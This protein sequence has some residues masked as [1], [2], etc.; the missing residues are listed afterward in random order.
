MSGICGEANDKTFFLAPDALRSST[1][2]LRTSPD[3]DVLYV[4]KTIV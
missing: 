4:L 2:I 1:N 3:L